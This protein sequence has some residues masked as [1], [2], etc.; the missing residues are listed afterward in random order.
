M[1]WLSDDHVGKPLMP[2]PLPV[3]TI[4]AWAALAQAISRRGTPTFP[5][6]RM[7]LVPTVSAFAQRLYQSGAS[8]YAEVA[9]FYALEGF[10]QR[11]VI[12]LQPRILRG[13]EEFKT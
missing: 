7:G 9:N 10:G 3:Q 4:A 8:A 11:G 1:N 2:R 5:E 13:D 12:E 6:Q